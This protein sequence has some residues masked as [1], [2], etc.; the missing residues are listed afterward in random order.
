MAAVECADPARA[1]RLGSLL[2]ALAASMPAPGPPV[3]GHG[4]F[5]AG[6]VVVTP[7]GRPV[8]LDVDEVRLSDRERDLGIAL[9]HLDWQGIRPRT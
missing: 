5:R 4:S 7:G 9:A 3:L 2:D 6:Q 1:I 8:L